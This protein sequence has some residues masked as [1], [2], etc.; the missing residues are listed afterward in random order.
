VDIAKSIKSIRS[1][2]LVQIA[3]LTISLVTSIMV[4]RYLGPE[5][6]GVLAIASAIVVLTSP[7]VG[8]PHGSLVV[9]ELAD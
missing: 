9:R 5:Q 4:I 8:L 6:Y 2:W 1:L 3:K 7:L